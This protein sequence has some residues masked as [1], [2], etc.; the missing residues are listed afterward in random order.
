MSFVYT[1]AAYKI[2][3]G[4]LAWH[5]APL[6]AL[7]VM[8]NTTADTDRDAA[9]LSQITTLDEFDG[10]GYSRDTDIGPGVS[11]DDPNNR[12]EFTITPINFGS[13]VAAGSRQIAGVVIY[14]HVTGLPA[15]DWPIFYIDSGGFPVTPG[16]GSLTVT[17]NAE[18]LAQLAS[19]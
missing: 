10:S 1:P 12:A 7:A 13:T 17:P 2:A 14:F 6:R 4:E 11:Q 19:A 15:D 9:T 16:G 8:T 18:G 3:R 5:V